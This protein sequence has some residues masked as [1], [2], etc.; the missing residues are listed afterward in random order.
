VCCCL[1]TWCCARNQ[2]VAEESEGSSEGSENCGVVASSGHNLYNH[3]STLPTAGLQEEYYS[4]SASSVVSSEEELEDDRDMGTVHIG[5]NFVGVMTKQCYSVLNRK[6]FGAENDLK[7]NRD[8]KFVAKCCFVG[9]RIPADLAATNN[10][11]ENQR[12]MLKSLDRPP[13]GSILLLLERNQTIG[14]LKHEFF[15]RFILQVPQS[16]CVLCWCVLFLTRV[17]FSSNSVTQAGGV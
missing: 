17:H 1:I 10:L 12:Q 6:Y 5:K 9:R 7:Y 16:C 8:G 3:M 14:D 11:D 4:S 13:H 15:K 2:K